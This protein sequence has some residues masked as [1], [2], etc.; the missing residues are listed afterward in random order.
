MVEYKLCS[1]LTSTR[2][3]FDIV[4]ALLWKRGAYLYITIAK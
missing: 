3:A 4:E 2:T 1:L